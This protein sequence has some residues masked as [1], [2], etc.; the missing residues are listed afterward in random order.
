MKI[1]IEAFKKEG[2]SFEEIES[3][4]TSIDNFTKTWIAH[5]HEEVKKSA[6]K[7]IFSKVSIHV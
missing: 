2:F 6:R 1:D 4:N 7:S 5:S 3:V